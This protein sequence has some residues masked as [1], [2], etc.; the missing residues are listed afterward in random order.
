MRTTSILSLGSV[1]VW[2]LAV[3]IAWAD[4]ESGK[5]FFRSIQGG[6]CKTCH[7]TNSLRLVGPGMENVTRRHTD[8]WLRL[9]LKDS[10]ETWRSD[11]PE[12]VELKERV[13]KT[14]VGATSCQKGEMTEVQL[15]DLLDFLDTLEDKE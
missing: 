15:G 7:Y 10:Q 4:P 14:R 3:S 5:E 2:A 6:N 11:H 1:L 12:T 13:R 8:E 9:W